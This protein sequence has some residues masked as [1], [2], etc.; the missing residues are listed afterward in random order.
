MPWFVTIFGRDSL[1]VSHQNM[2]IHPLFAR[3]ALQKLAEYKRWRW[4]TGG[5]PSPAKSCTSSG[6]ASW[7]TSTRFPH[8]VLWHG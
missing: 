2:I 7:R 8:T 4:M 6:S 3:G 1:I 5:T